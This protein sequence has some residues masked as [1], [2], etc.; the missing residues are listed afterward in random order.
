MDAYKF[1]Q[2]VVKR[3]GLQ[4]AVFKIPT[5][6]NSIGGIKDAALFASGAISPFVGPAAATAFTVASTLYGIK[7]IYDG[8][9]S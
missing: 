1:G 6:Y 5:V 7:S 8:F 9:T 3:K 4:S 2:Y